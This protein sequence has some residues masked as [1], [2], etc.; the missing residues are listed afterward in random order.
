M[1]QTISENIIN[2]LCT[3]VMTGAVGVITHLF[4]QFKGMNKAVL[5]MNHDRLYQACTFLS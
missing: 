1:L 5:A 4:K 2:I 3:V